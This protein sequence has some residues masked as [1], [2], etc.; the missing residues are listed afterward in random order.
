MKINNRYYMNLINDDLIIKIYLI[1]IPPAMTFIFFMA[2][3]SFSMVSYSHNI[4]YTLIV[5]N[6]KK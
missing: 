6:F 2:K 4:N 5:I 1:S 3:S